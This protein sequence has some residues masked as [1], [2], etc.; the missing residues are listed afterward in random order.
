[1]LTLVFGRHAQA[2]QERTIDRCQTGLIARSQEIDEPETVEMELIRRR[3]Y[4]AVHTALQIAVCPEMQHVGCVDDDA[5]GN[6]S[7][8]FPFGVA[9]LEL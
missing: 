4:D 7:D 6:V 3:R 5:A 9:R 2:A 1:M 8:V